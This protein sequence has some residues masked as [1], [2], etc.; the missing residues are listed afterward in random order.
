MSDID[1]NAYGFETLAKIT[2]TRRNEFYKDDSHEILEPLNDFVEM[3]F[4]DCNFTLEIDGEIYKNFITIYGVSDDN[5]TKILKCNKPNLIFK[6]SLYEYDKKSVFNPDI[7]NEVL[8]YNQN[9]DIIENEA[10]KQIGKSFYIPMWEDNKTADI[11]LGYMMENGD[12]NMRIVGT[13]DYKYLSSD[14]IRLTY[15]DKTNLHDI[16]KKNRVII[17]NMISMH[18]KGIFHLDIKPENI[19]LAGK[20]IDFGCSSNVEQFHNKLMDLY[21]GNTNEIR[22]GTLGYQAPELLMFKSFYNDLP[23]IE[24]LPLIMSQ[25][26]IFSMGCTIFYTLF[27]MSFYDDSV[28]NINI[29]WKNIKYRLYG[30]KFVDPNDNTVDTM[31][32]YQD[33]FGK[34]GYHLQLLRQMNEYSVY[35]TDM[36]IYLAMLRLNPHERADVDLIG[37]F[38]IK[39][40]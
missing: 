4:V 38:I 36:S 21:M 13:N 2:F 11:L 40:T 12:K 25:M 32:I 27:G 22:L 3:D 17:K 10:I 33:Y 23:S 24:D 35:H 16:V 9:N 8:F 31:K 5:A 7:M 1:Y 37:K 18:K 19:T 26:D 20:F 39:S 30:E 28:A 29:D 14:A 34:D 6:L 15:L